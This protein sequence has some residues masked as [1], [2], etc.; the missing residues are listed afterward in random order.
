MV[1]ARIDAAGQGV[2]LQRDSKA[3]DDGPPELE[4]YGE[5]YRESSAQK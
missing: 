5:R 4:G 2:R 3:A 1:Q